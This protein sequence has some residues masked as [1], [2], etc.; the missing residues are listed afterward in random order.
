MRPS[1]TMLRKHLRY[2]PDTGLLW[3]KIYRQGRR[4]YIPAGCIEPNGYN[5]VVFSGRPYKGHIL[6]W[7][8]VKGRWPKR[9][10]DH[11]DMVRNNNKWTNLRLATRG[12]NKQNG[13]CYRNNKA[14]IK[15]V[16]Q[17]DGRWRA[18]IQY[19][20]KQHYLGLFDTASL[21]AAA[22]AK[23]AKKHHKEFARS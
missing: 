13:R 7:V 6:A 8:I 5:V 21:A 18:D 19:N 20:G 2:D 23:A 3:W 17:Q 1:A 14:G 10:L 12:Q 16:F 22:Y 9:Q 11:K 4:M 15:G